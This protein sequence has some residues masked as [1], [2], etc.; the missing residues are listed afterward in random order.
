MVYNPATYRG[1]LNLE[2]FHHYVDQE[3]Q[4][5]SQEIAESASS[6][7]PPLFDIRDFYDPASGPEIAE[8]GRAAIAAAVAGGIGG[9]IYIPSGNW[10]LT[11]DANADVAADGNVAIWDVGVN[12]NIWIEGDGYG[13]VLFLH[14]AGTA[15]Q[16]LMAINFHGNDGTSYTTSGNLVLGTRTLTLGTGQ[17]ISA[18]DKHELY[19]DD[20]AGYFHYCVMEVA[21]YV[22]G[23]G[24]VT[25]KKPSPIAVPVAN[26]TVRKMIF[27]EGGGVRNLRFD[28]TNALQTT[29]NSA[30]G[31]RVNNRQHWTAE[32]LWFNG[33]SGNAPGSSSSA[34]L[35]M[36]KGYENSL[37]RI[38][39][40]HGGSAGS[41]DIYMTWQHGL[42]TDELVSIN[43]AGFGIGY[44][45]VTQGNFGRHH[46]NG[47][48]ESGR[49]MKVAGI[50]Y[51]A[52][53]SAIILGAFSTGFAVAEGSFGNLFGQIICRQ[54]IAFTSGQNVGLWF[55][56]QNNQDNHINSV[57]AL[58]WADND[59]EFYTSDTHNSIDFVRADTIFAQG[60]P[61][62]GFLKHPIGTVATIPTISG[63]GNGIIRSRVTDATS[64]TAGGVVAGGGAFIVPVYYDGTNWRVG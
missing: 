56:D 45:A 26:L 50:T 4:K 39:A 6:S 14:N 24:V 34:G 62:I 54:D 5:I 3:L 38:R 59:V 31:V 7:L 49:A 55:S 41:D 36:T 27:S 16:N 12:S 28:G 32:N 52:M 60:G 20:A 17:S 40:E 42:T 44:N 2:N 9:R 53:E 35:F 10:T 61:H 30:W 47:A 57:Y 21:S 11:Y 58:G 43:P 46:V 48:S 23:T 13:T 37:R 64:R 33:F 63:G 51:C 22:S 19:G 25:Y 1:E 29:T 18:G 15:A 8:A